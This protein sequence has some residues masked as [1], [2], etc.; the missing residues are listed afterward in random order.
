[1]AFGGSAHLIDQDMIGK[2]FGIYLKKNVNEQ[3][4]L[5]A[6]GNWFNEIMPEGRV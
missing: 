5:G 6:L 1:M 2:G 4:K 3:T